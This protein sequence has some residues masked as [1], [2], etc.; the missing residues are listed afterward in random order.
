MTYALDHNS[1][2]I[3][4]MLIFLAAF[5]VIDHNIRFGRLQYIF[6]I[7]GTDTSLIPSYLTNRSKCVS[8]GSVYSDNMVLKYGVLQGSVLGP[9]FYFFFVP[10]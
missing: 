5:D 4:L 2:V 6:G 1:C 3:L 8:I 10:G 9:I 7:S